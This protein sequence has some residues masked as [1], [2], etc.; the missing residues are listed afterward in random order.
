MSVAK[1]WSGASNALHVVVATPLGEGGRGGIDRIVDEIRHQLAAVPPDDVEVAFLTTRG[2]HHILFSPFYFGA[3][4][5]KLILLRLCGR[6][7][8]LHVNL[9]SHGS[10]VRK[11]LM[12]RLAGLLSI[13]YIVH[14]HG[15]RFRAFYR[16]AGPMG[17]R[18][19]LA[20]FGGAARIVVLGAVWRSFVI[21]LSPTLSDR[22]EILP[23]ATRSPPCVHGR[24]DRAVNVLFLGKVG[25][26]KGVPQ[27]VEAFDR[28]AG[29]PGWVG[30]IAGDG[31]VELTRSEIERRGMTSR[32]KLT[33]W[34]AP[35]QVDGLLANA[36][37]LVLPSFDENLPMSVIEAMG[38]GL[39]V[40]A[41]PVGAVA[42]IIKHDETG[43]LVPAGDS[44]RLADAI[45]QL[46]NDPA[47]RERLGINARAF[48]R[49]HLN[50]DSYL[51]RL[52]KI[53]RVAA[54]KRQTSS[55]GASQ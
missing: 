1:P 2:R 22:V 20:M 4:L 31:D 37:I 52:L 7:D 11:A 55:V 33:G 15:S 27:L 14:L 51:P 35:A 34:V 13:P 32:V 26:R 30:I 38:H 19:I 25:K 6:A 47:M 40:V 46:I 41:T 10:T 3:A 29:A 44:E 53:W 50:I 48:H 42:D 21:D 9:S 24:A 54:A 17:R 49:E 39:A 45:G 23:N 5:C 28:L 43:L 18:D 16:D 12:C 36:D 8:V